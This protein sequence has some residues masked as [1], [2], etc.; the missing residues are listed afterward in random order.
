MFTRSFEL[1]PETQ[2]ARLMRIPRRLLPESAT[3]RLL[4]GYSILIDA[5]S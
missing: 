5:Y 1:E 4:G 3:I 2:K